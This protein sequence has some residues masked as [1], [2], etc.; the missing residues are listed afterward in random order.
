MISL[1]SVAKLCRVVG[2]SVDEI[3]TGGETAS[4]HHPGSVSLIYSNVTNPVP[5]TFCY[6]FDL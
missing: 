1:Y 2:F 3:V 4:Y 6:C 5:I